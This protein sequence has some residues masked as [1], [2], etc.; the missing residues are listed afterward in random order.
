MK[1]NEMPDEFMTGSSQWGLRRWYVKLPSGRFRKII[2]GD[3]N[4]AVMPKDEI[5]W[6]EEAY[7]VW[8]SLQA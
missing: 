1:F 3:V 7:R 2:V 8:C 4:S 6:P 5:V